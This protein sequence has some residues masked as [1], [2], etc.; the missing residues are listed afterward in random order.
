MHEVE[1]RQ[2]TGNTPLVITGVS[3][4]DVQVRLEIREL[5]KNDIQWSLFLLGMQKF[6]KVGQAEKTSWYS[7]SGELKIFQ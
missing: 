5:A 1:R 7:V 3:Q 4:N 2:D 6:Q